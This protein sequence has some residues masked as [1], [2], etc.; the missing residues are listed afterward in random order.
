MQF[1]LSPEYV[2]DRIELYEIN[3]LMKYSYYNSKDNWEQARLIAYLQAQTHSSKKLK[4]D[5]IIKFPWEKETQHDTYI[6]TE[7]INRL[8]DMAEQYE[9]LFAE[10]Q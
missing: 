6:S 8:S 1:G 7:D 3:A 2:L 9:R 10:Q 4:V 5:D